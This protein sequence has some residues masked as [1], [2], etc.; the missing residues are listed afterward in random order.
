MKL[1]RCSASQRFSKSSILCQPLKKKKTS[2]L[3]PFHYAYQANKEAT[4]YFAVQ[5]MG[6]RNLGNTYQ[7]VFSFCRNYTATLTP[8]RIKY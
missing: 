5:Q 1:A 8:H 6:S 3:L 7:T 2:F 4:I